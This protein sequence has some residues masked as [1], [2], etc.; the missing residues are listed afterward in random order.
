MQGLGK[1]PGGEKGYFSETGCS[2][3]TG[4][5]DMAFVAVSRDGSSVLS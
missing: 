3:K 2:M 5:K 4:R 1:P